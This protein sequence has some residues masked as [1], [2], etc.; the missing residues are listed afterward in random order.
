MPP[1][2]LFKVPSDM[3]SFDI[4]CA[5]CF[6]APLNLQH[7]AECLMHTKN[8]VIVAEF[9]RIINTRRRMEP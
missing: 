4:Y 5:L 8:S 2:V 1:R 9:K 3:G 7:L 6:V